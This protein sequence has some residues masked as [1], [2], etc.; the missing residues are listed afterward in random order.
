VKGVW[1]VSHPPP[2]PDRGPAVQSRPMR[3]SKQGPTEGPAAAGG[4]EADRSDHAAAPV[5]IV[6]VGVVALVAG[7]LLRFTTASSLWLDESLSVNIAELPVGDIF[8]WL[9]H[10]GHPPLYYLILHGW[11]EVF[12]SAD[13]SVRALS[14][15]FGLLTLPLAYI[16][17]RR[18]GGSLLGWLT[19]TVFALS[20]FM[21]RY[22]SEARMYS[23]VMLL[24]VAGYLLVDDVVRRGR[25]NVLR[26]VGIALVAG[27]LLYTHYWALWLLG[28][29]GLVLGWRAWR[30]A[31][32]GI[33]FPALQAA[34]ALVVGALLFVPWIPSMLYQSAHT[35][36]PWA[37]PS[38][39]TTAAAF[40]FND[41]AS[42]LYSDAGFFA[43]V[44]GALM[45]LAVFG[46]AVDSRRIDLDLR[47]RPQFRAEALVAGLTFVLA[48]SVSYA[49]R[50]AFAT[51]YAAV[52]MPF[53]ALLVAGG[54]TRF[55]ARWV[56]LGAV[57]AVCAFMSVGALWN[58]SDTRTQAGQAG[59]AIDANA[60]P[61]DLVVY[62]PD[63]LGPAGSRAVTADVEEV[64]YPTFGDPR[65]VDW[66]DY[67]ER[68]DATDPVAFSQRVLD[69][70]GPD[71][72]IFVVW[73]GSYKTFQNDCEQL[74]RAIGTWRPGQELIQENG[75]FFE[76]AYVQW[77]PAAA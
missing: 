65:L 50:G 9:R 28:A 43:I 48:I 19:V 8:S 44:L 55:T 25:N 53:L 13:A 2:R 42:G 58:L 68:N 51:R 15:V 56:R 61:G 30:N 46:R 31:D 62:C 36:T 37:T 6:V 52:V 10:D 12:G 11:M 27:A 18:L 54:L 72:A 29:T 34:G 59:R 69:E 66:V 17:G 16:A 73:S 14:G 1:G 38:R 32:R 47:T 26:L 60:Q 21:V 24:A 39:P 77:Y 35:G 57:L 74:V 41:L 71:R 76:K 7:V 33:R 4:S 5:E 49:L 75:T 63:Q 67:K 23:L 64:A 20:A 22:S 40:T 70:A 45:L 3:T